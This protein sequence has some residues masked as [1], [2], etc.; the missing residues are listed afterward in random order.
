MIQEIVKGVFNPGPEHSHDIQCLHCLYGANSSLCCRDRCRGLS[1]HLPCFCF[2][3]R[4]FQVN[5]TA[6]STFAEG[7]PLELT[8]LVVGSGQDPQ[9]QGLWIFNGVEMARIDTGG[10]LHLKTDYKERASQGQLQI[11]KRSPKA[12]SLKIFAAGPE[13]EGTYRCAVAEM[14]RAQRG[15]W[16]V[17]Q[18]KQSPDS[19]V[20]LRK[21]AGK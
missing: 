18:T 21:P 20:R 4:D 9:L 8:C 10:V 5:I 1:K 16:Q 15:S 6:I 2:L 3:V 13:D 11:S 17:V 12:F 7:K 19:R 14:V